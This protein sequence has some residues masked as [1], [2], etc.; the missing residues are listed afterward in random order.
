[1]TPEYLYSATRMCVTGARLAMGVTCGVVSL[2][3]APY[4]GRLLTGVR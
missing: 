4:L 2:Y 3:S 1:M